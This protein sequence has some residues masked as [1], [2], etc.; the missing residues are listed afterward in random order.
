MGE[1]EHEAGDDE[2]KLEKYRE[3]VK[4]LEEEHN[5][6]VPIGGALSLERAQELDRRL[7]EEKE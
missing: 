7:H 6:R 5:Y 4:H 2:S 3:V 1:G